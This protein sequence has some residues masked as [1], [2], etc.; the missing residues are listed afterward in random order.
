[1]LPFSYLISFATRVPLLRLV[2]YK[3]SNL[4]IFGLTSTQTHGTPGGR[5]AMQLL[6]ARDDRFIT[7]RTA[8]PEAL[9]RPEDLCTMLPD[10]LRSVHGTAMYETDN[11]SCSYIVVS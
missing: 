2:A 1:V 9:Y 10:S 6:Q 3:I 8:E 4:A 7:S 5:N 11:K